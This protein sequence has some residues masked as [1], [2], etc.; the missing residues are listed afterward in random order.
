MNIGIVILDHIRKVMRSK[1]TDGHRIYF[2]VEENG[3]IVEMPSVD[4]VSVL[5]ERRIG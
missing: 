2:S 5:S 1:W 4:L 3:A